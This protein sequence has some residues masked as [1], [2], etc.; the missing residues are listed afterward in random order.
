M[1]YKQFIVS[2]VELIMLSWQQILQ[3]NFH[4]MRTTSLRTSLLFY[5][6]VKLDIH[7]LNGLENIPI[8]D[9]WKL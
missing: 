6:Y 7:M 5:H 1:S 9:I 4:N 3:Y 2:I 8:F